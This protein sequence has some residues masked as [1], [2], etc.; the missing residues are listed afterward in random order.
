M[1]AG[2]ASLHQRLETCAAN[3]G[4]RGR[5][6]GLPKEASGGGKA[7]H[8]LQWLCGQ[9]VPANAFSQ[10]ELDKFE[11]MKKTGVV[12][13][14]AE[15]REAL[16]KIEGCSGSEGKTMEQ[17][18][19][20]ISCL[21]QS[22]SS[23]KTQLQSINNIQT[24][25]SV[26]Q[27]GL[28]KE[29]E[30]ESLTHSHT[31]SSHQTALHTAQQDNEMVNSAVEGLGSAVD[32][33]ISFHQHPQGEEGGGGELSLFSHTSSE[34]YSSAEDAY[35]TEL[36]AYTKKQFFQGIAVMAH[37]SGED[38]DGLVDLNDPA[39]ILMRGPSSEQYSSHCRE[40]TRLKNLYPVV[41]SQRVSDILAEEYAEAVCRRAEELV[42]ELR[43]TSS[44]LDSSLL[45]QHIGERRG[46]LSHLQSET[47]HLA[48]QQLP[49]LIHDVATLEISTIL[50]GDY[51]LKMARQDY[52]TSKQD[53]V[54]SYLLSQTA[55]QELLS[56][57]YEVELRRHR[58]THRLLSAAAS[59]L[60]S[61]GSSADSRLVSSYNTFITAGGSKFYTQSQPQV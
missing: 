47:C 20:E 17:L 59:Q 14:G 56:M 33:V 60:L 38:E 5:V 42:S 2:P 18:R 1:A 35:L 11:E 31:V 16:G 21:E 4:Y 30:E 3:V 12:L 23:L 61:W 52:F 41:E 49:N 26:H 53:T 39:N 48:R 37:T 58:D 46:Q 25:L 44:P 28:L 27:A 29:R 6:R 43:D 19:A 22:V 13:E 36:T 24:T 50:H 10:S 40:L 34:H 9:L 45:R 55:R 54:I 57:L 8:F 7:A 51:S 32:D 15:L